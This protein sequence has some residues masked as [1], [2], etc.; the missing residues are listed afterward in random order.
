[1]SPIARIV[2]LLPF[3]PLL[4]A[5]WWDLPSRLGDVLSRESS[6]R[7]V[8]TFEQR[9][10]MEDRTNCLFG[11]DPDRADILVRT[12]VGLTVK[13]VKWLKLSGMFQDSRAPGYGTVAPPS[14]RNPTELHEAYVAL[15][16]GAFGFEAG[17]AMLNYG[18][19]MLIGT[20]Q[21]GNVSRTYDHAR[22]SYRWHGLKTEFLIVSPVKVRVNDF[23]RPVPGDRAWGSYNTLSNVWEK[24]QAEFYIL[25]HDQ[26]RPGGY[27]GSG[28]LATNTFGAR[29]SGPLWSASRFSVE[30]DWQ[31]GTIGGAAHRALGLHGTFTRRHRVWDRNLDLFGEFNYASGTDDPG[32]TSRVATF[33]QVFAAHHDRFGHQDLIG[34]RNI[35]E[36]RGLA[37]L[38]LTRRVNLNAMLSDFWL[39]SPRDALYSGG[40]A[41]I[42]RSAD[43]SA[44]RHVGEEADVFATLKLKHS[45][46]GVGY[47]HF[48]TG[49]FLRHTTPGMSQEY[50]YFF[51]TY[52]F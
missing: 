46:L 4:L 16:P 10:R 2:A 45:T 26:N 41:A 6:N 13:P 38:G 52:S 7:V 31:N 50:V 44:G 22:L 40:G 27:T 11:R 5:D 3:T 36:C 23:D 28:R 37:T 48:F 43:G 14:V 39:D 25:R 15:T 32:R 35:W 9:V 33:D 20:P 42:A 24:T 21:W 47:G 18:D 34:W 49:E 1:M 17:R 29:W 12:R 19:G 8:V 51:H 30:G